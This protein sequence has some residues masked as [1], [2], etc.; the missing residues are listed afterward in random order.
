MWIWVTHTESEPSTLWRWIRLLSSAL[1]FIGAVL[2]FNGYSVKLYVLKLSIPLYFRYNL[3]I[4]QRRE[5]KT[6]KAYT[7]IKFSLQKHETHFWISVSTLFRLYLTNV[8]LVNGARIEGHSISHSKLFTVV[9][10]S[11]VRAKTVHGTACY[12]SDLGEGSFQFWS[13]WAMHTLSQPV[14]CQY[15]EYCKKKKACHM[16]GLFREIL[17]Y[18]KIFI[19]RLSWLIDQLV[20]EYFRQSLHS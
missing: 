19:V 9:Q 7:T 11:V 3:N 4:R 17:R 13:L 2:N 16:N 15:S 6:L 12:N 1:W 18:F 10:E 14:S 8:K 20:C 5:G